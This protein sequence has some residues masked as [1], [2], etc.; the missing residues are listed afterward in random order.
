METGARRGPR[1]VVRL[2]AVLLLTGAALGLVAPTAGASCAGPRL[3]VVGAPTSD[4]SL[5]AADTELP[6]VRVREG[7]ALRVEVSNVNDAAAGC[8]DVGGGCDDPGPA[9][10]VP[11]R[12]VSLVLE[13]GD[14]RWTLG[15]ADATGPERAVRYDV[16]L[17]GAV[18]RGE[19]DLVLAGPVLGAGVQARLVVA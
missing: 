16:V 1:S 6:V 2:L 4:P 10:P 15:T 5:V 8:D 13:Q 11:A 7:Q 9:A 3:S 18:A 14:R 17:P 12:G 19:A